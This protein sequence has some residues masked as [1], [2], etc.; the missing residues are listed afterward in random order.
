MDSEADPYARRRTGHEGS[1]WVDAVTV[2]QVL[3]STAAARSELDVRQLAGLVYAAKHEGKGL[4]GCRRSLVP[5]ASEGK[6]LE[7]RGEGG[8][9]GREASVGTLKS[10]GQA[11]DRGGLRVWARIGVG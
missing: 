3:T 4:L 5:L 8:E 10:L 1:H 9:G 6:E 7:V 11:Q 2:E